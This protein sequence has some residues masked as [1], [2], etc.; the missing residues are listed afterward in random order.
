MSFDKFLKFANIVGRQGGQAGVVSG[1]WSGGQQT[2]K[3]RTHAHHRYIRYNTVLAIS[4]SAMFVRCQKLNITAGRPR[5]GFE[6]VA[7]IKY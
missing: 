4:C 3:N 6:V 1:R 2:I 7:L 5:P